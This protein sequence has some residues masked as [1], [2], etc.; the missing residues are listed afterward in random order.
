MLTM[1]KQN[2]SS[3]NAVAAHY[4]DVEKVESSIKWP[5]GIGA[6]FLAGMGS[7]QFTATDEKRA[8]A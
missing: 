8:S 1:E 7:T 3:S 6:Q 4:E 5:R 2:E